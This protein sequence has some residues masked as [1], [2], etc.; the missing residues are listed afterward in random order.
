MRLKSA[1]KLESDAALARLINITPAAIGVWRVRGSLDHERLIALC[2]D[3]RLDLHYIFFGTKQE[4]PRTTMSHTNGQ[5]SHTSNDL[6]VQTL[7]KTV[8]LLELR[9]AES[10]KTLQA[11]EQV[12][13]DKAAQDRQLKEAQDQ[14]IKL[15]AELL[16]TTKKLRAATSEIQSLKKKKAA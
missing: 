3:R 13:Q 7:L 11:A 5:G 1:L 6:L 14:I 4:P 12:L 10:D 15:Q 8:Q 9:I 2:N 16:E